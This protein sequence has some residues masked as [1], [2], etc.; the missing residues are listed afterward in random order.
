MLLAER[1]DDG[2][3]LNRRSSLLLAVH[4]ADVERSAEGIATV[5]AK[6]QEV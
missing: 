1:I 4:V 3:T 2:I 5:L 6:T